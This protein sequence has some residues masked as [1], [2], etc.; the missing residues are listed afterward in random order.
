MEFQCTAKLEDGF[1]TLRYESPGSSP[2]S[3]VEAVEGEAEI[4]P[5]REDILRPIADNFGF[6]LI[7]RSRA[8]G[9]PTVLCLGNHSSGKSTFLNHLAGSHIQDTGV[10]PTDDGFTLLTY[11][12]ID[13]TLDGRAV[14]TNPALPYG[15][16]EQ[17][18]KDFLDHLRLKRRPNSNLRGV[19]FIDSP[20]MIDHAGV[21]GDSS[22]GYDFKSVVRAFAES[23]DLVLFFFDPD[24]PG[25]TGESLHIFTDALTD[26]M[27][28]LLIVFNKVDSF[29][30]VRD[31]ART[32]GALCWN[33]SR[34]V[35]TKDMPRIYCTFISDSSS[36]IPGG[37]SGTSQPDAMPGS[38]L[39]R[40]IDLTDFE[41]STNELKAEVAQVGRR[42][43]SNQLWGLL[44]SARQLRVHS[45]VIRR[46]SWRMAMEGLALLAAL[47]ALLIGGVTIAWQWSDSTWL[48]SIGCGLAIVAIL[49]GLALPSILQWRR[50][51]HIANLD[52][53]FRV[54]FE[55]S[56]LLQQKPEFL[57]GLWK[58]VR[59]KSEKFL[60]SVRLT[61]LP[62]SPWWIPK[63]RKLDQAIDTTIPQLM[64]SQPLAP[65]STTTQG[66]P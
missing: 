27:Y 38:K 9:V 51:E 21:Q 64:R 61:H 23:A 62:L 18:G 60:S 12:E 20:G 55:Q 25:T 19:C 13:E 29:G 28:K 59:P 46:V 41:K 50:R 56:F 5:I 30:D 1:M 34:V 65:P 66:T 35:R 33:L 17:Y 48:L 26:V 32:Y 11:G 58:C 52:Q 45:R 36:G 44:D 3:G 6:P 16:F 39:G 15:D 43:R 54:E 53:F 14:V 24:K 22:R 57:E 47:V 10:A 49:L 31:F 37:R 4:Q 8:S 63:L 42:R 7:G 2:R 40:S